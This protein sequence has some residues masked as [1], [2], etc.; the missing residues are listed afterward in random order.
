ME[1]QSVTVFDGAPYRG[2]ILL[3]D[4]GLATANVANSLLFD[5]AIIVFKILGYC[6][7]KFMAAIPVFQDG[8]RETAFCFF[9]F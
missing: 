9:S 8:C 3:S 6:I 2:K 4:Q 1:S 7:P 5:L